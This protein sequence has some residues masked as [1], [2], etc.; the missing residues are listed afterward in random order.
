MDYGTESG[1][2]VTD[3]AGTTAGEFSWSFLQVPHGILTNEKSLSTA[4]VQPRPQYTA[5]KTAGAKK[6]D[7]GGWEETFGCPTRA[8]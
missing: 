4:V 8:A 5:S 6:L 7:L 1:Q 2:A 3:T